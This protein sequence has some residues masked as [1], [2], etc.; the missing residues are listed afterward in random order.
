MPAPV[1]HSCCLPSARR[2]EQEAVVGDRVVHRQPRLP[3]H[4]VAVGRCEVVGWKTG[5]ASYVVRSQIASTGSSALVRTRTV[6]VSP[7]AGASS[8]T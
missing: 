8:E 4:D 2:D 5:S 7:S 3:P 1:S 6:T